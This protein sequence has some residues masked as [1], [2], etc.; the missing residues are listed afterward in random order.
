MTRADV[1]N[2]PV[3]SARSSQAATI[4]YVYLYM[5]YIYIYIYIYIHYM[6]RSLSCSRRAGERRSAM[7]AR[8]WAAAFFQPSSCGASQILSE[9]RCLPWLSKHSMDF[10]DTYE[11]QWCAAPCQTQRNTWSGFILP[12][13]YVSR[14]YKFWILNAFRRVTSFPLPF[15]AYQFQSLDPFSHLWI[16]DKKTN[17]H[18]DVGRSNPRIWRSTWYGPDTASREMHKKQT[19]NHTLLN[20]SLNSKGAEKTLSI[21]RG[22]SNPEMK[23]GSQRWSMIYL[24]DFVHMI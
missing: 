3:K 7:A 10:S 9:H 4:I 14:V 21:K 1:T 12:F 24:I 6:F 11:N 17:N 15:P 2:R 19:P 23:P 5:C 22:V 20:L 18:L 8:V 16:D 13:F